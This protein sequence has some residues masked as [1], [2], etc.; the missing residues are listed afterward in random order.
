MKMKNKDKEKKI[1]PA[2]DDDSVSRQP[3]TMA[4]QNNLYRLPCS[5][6]SVKEGWNA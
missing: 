2:D 5:D 4:A 3:L 6:Q 1:N